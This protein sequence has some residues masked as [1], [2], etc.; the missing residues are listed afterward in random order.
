MTFEKARVLYRLKF[1]FMY[2]AGSNRD[3]NKNTKG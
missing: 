3:L 2:I 1:S